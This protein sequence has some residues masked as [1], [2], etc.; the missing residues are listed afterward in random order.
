MNC[1][2]CN[3]VFSGSKCPRC[4]FPV[5]ESTDVDV[6]IESM[7]D[8]IESYRREF[9]STLEISLTVYHWKADGSKIVPT[10]KSRSY[11]G[12]FRELC[13]N[14][15]LF[16]HKFARIPDKD[17]LTVEVF[18]SSGDSERSANVSL[19]NIKEPSLQRI[20]IETDENMRFR[21]SLMNGLGSLTC[22][23]WIPI[24]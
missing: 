1:L 4:G 19:P 9:L 15:K 12:S 5:I 24:P 6:L 8:Q 22:S 2:V 21:V 3:Q 17:E 10:E 13:G 18:F 11:L 20:G 7:H 23:E 14:P 16:A